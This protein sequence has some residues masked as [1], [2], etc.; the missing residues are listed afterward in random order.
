MQKPTALTIDV[1]ERDLMARLDHHIAT[2][3]AFA[4]LTYTA[5]QLPLGDAII[6]TDEHPHAVIERK[7]VA[8]LFASIKDGR[9]EEQSC[10]LSGTP[11]WPNHN[12]LYLV[13]GPTPRGDQL[14]T[15]HS[16]L[17][18]LNYYKGFSVVR[19]YSVDET[20]VFILNTMRRIERN[21]R[22][23]KYPV[24][25]YVEAGAGAPIITQPVPLVSDVPVEG[26]NEVTTAAQPAQPDAYAA[27]IKKVKKD[28]ITPQNIGQIMLSTIPGVST[29]TA[30]IIMAKYGTVAALITAMRE[31]GKDDL[32]GLVDGNGRKISK[33]AIGNVYTYLVGTVV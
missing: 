33:T 10:R 4:E 12:I 27:S 8:D 26:E 13:E 32:K 11:E 9:Y 7:A 18:S 23:K 28:N 19:T 2:N 31:Q 21:W 14:A 17:F 30:A 3:K 6:A 20:A 25:G 24:W 29:A 22:D 15:F 1:R 5:K 16:S